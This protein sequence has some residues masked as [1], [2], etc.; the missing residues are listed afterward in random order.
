MAVRVYQPRQQRDVAKIV[1]LFPSCVRERIPA[2][3][4]G[5]PIARNQDRA[6][7]L[8]VDL[9]IGRGLQPFPQTACESA[10]TH[11]LLA[12]IEQ[13]V[14]AKGR[15]N[16]DEEPL[17]LNGCGARPVQAPAPSPIVLMSLRQLF[18]GELHSCIARLRF[19]GRSI[20][21]PGPVICQL[22]L[23]MSRIS[24]GLGRPSQGKLLTSQV[25]QIR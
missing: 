7:A 14:A 24:P 12:D 21:R 8:Q 6:V 1:S 23:R 25:G 17:A 2:A 18:L 11:A 13:T 5:N 9:L 3:D 16:G 20:F 15:G 22:L 10:R 4:R 19:A